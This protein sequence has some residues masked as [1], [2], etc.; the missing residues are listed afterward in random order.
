MKAREVQVRTN[1]RN[2]LKRVDT[3]N[4]GLIEVDFEAIVECFGLIQFKVQLKHCST[5][6]K[7]FI[8]ATT[9]SPSLYS[10]PNGMFANIAPVDHLQNVCHSKANYV[11]RKPLLFFFLFLLYS[12]QSLCIHH[13][14]HTSTVLVINNFRDQKDL[15]S[16]GKQQI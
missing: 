12:E 9:Y 11:R 7:C 3:R 5:G 8:L 15:Y 1:T 2:K 4:G 6:P 13:K 16:N 10:Y 14:N